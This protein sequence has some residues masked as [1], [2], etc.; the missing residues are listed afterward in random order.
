MKRLSLA[1]VAALASLC[2]LAACDEPLDVP[3]LEAEQ[4]GYRGTGMEEVVNP[5]L[6][7]VL[8][9]LNEV[10]EPI[11]PPEPAGDGPMAT[12]IYENVQVLTDLTAAQFDRLMAHMTEWIA[13]ADQACNYCHNPENLADG[14]KYT[15]QVSRYMLRMTRHINSEW[16]SHVRQ[17]GVTCYTCHRGNAVPML[18]NPGLQEEERLAYWFKA[19]PAG[20]G[21][22]GYRAEQNEPLSEVNHSSLPNTFQ[23][24]YLLGDDNIRVINQRPLPIQGEDNV[25]IKETEW[26]YALM[27]HMS[28]SL[29]V[30]CTYCHNSR[31]FANWQQSPPVRTNAWY[32]IRMTRKI[33]ND[34]MLPTRDLFAQSD[35][36]NRLGPTGDV[37]KVSCVTCHQKVAKPL[38]GTPMLADFP[39]LWGTGNYEQSDDQLTA[40]AE[41]EADASAGGGQ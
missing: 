41:A 20:G 9:E 10:P 36:A 19:E 33:N 24:R 38:Y 32:G 29:G 6:D 35:R 8:R 34:Y 13:P 28:Q 27:I 7:A 14:S 1:P 23:E 5:R 2:V 40:E 15:Y 3:P 16:E 22:L 12:E 18:E 30:N 21:A 25:G 11:Y 37:G 4:I 39:E 31:A 17:K 26:T